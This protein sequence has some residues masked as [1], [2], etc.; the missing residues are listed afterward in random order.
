LGGVLFIIAFIPSIG[1]KTLDAFKIYPAFAGFFYKIFNKKKLSDLC[2]V[3]LHKKCYNV[4]KLY[5]KSYPHETEKKQVP[6]Q[7]S[8]DPIIG[9]YR[10]AFCN[11]R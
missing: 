1:I 8:Q 7:N 3:F 4:T 10:T 6:D 11:F 5:F 2:L 9:I